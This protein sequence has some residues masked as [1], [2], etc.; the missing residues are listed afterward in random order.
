MLVEDHLVNQEIV[1][2]LLHNSGIG[3]DIANNGAEAVETF[4]SNPDKYDL[5]LMDIQMPIMDGYEA[6]KIIRSIR[7]T[8][9]PIIALTAN[10]MKED[11]QRTKAVGMNEHL[12]KP[13][14]VTKLYETLLRNIKK[15]HDVDLS[16]TAVAAADHTVI[17]KFNTIDTALGLRY[18]AN[19]KKLY[20]KILKKFY[21]RYNNFHFNDLKEEERTRAVHTLKGL[22]GNIGATSL[23]LIAKEL[24]ET[25]DLHLQPKLEDELK[26]VLDELKENT[27]I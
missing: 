5:I 9:P 4:K 8:T 25:Q 15:R 21:T 1:L 20:I 10:A 22:S 14:E 6:T 16:A 24:D 2:G 27:L 23:H 17:P 11:R 18:L 19:S 13:I 12:N 3:I 7:N 26:K